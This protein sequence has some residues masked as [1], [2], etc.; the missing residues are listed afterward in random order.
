MEIVLVDILALFINL[1]EH[2][3]ILPLHVS[4]KFYQ[5]FLFI[6]LYYYMIFLIILLVCF[7]S[8]IFY[9]FHFFFLNVVQ[10]GYFLM[11]SFFNL[12]SL[13]SA[14]SNQLLNPSNKFLVSQIT[15]SVFNIQLVFSFRFKFSF[16]IL[17]IFT[18]FVHVF[19]CLL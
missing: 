16:K 17:Q 1:R 19:L 4:S 2:A 3:Y 8:V 6:F 11:T 12:L 14:L 9:S 7:I 18:Y 10:F 13:S 15:F 5:M